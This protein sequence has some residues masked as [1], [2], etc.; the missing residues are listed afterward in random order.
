MEKESCVG[1]RPD[2]PDPEK[3]AHIMRDTEIVPVVQRHCNSVRVAGTR[4]RKTDKS[5]VGRMPAEGGISLR[6]KGDGTQKG[7]RPLCGPRIFPE[8]S[9]E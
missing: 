3:A 2:S 9:L 5:L 4:I 7:S 6:E 1:P 8:E